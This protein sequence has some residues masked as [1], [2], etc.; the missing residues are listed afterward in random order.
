M[1]FDALDGLL[2]V[3]RGSVTRLAIGIS[4]AQLKYEGFRKPRENH[5]SIIPEVFEVSLFIFYH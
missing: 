2:E 5:C 4:Y 1:A 3:S